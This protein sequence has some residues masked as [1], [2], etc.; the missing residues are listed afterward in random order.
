[1]GRARDAF[2]KLVMDLA[3]WSGEEP[4]PCPICEVEVDSVYAGH[5]DDCSLSAVAQI[6]AEPPPVRPTQKGR[7]RLPD[8]RRGITQKAK[9]GGQ[10]LFMRTGEY[11]DGSLGEIFIDMSKE[12]SLL[13][14]MMNSFCIAVSLGLQH[15]VP[16]QKY[17][18]LF[19][20]SRFE[21][22]GPVQGHARIKMAS[23]F[24]DLVFRDL[25]IEYL[26]LQEL[27]HVSLEDLVDL[28]AGPDGLSP[29]RE[30]VEVLD[31]APAAADLPEPLVPLSTYESEV[32]ATEHVASVHVAPMNQAG[33]RQMG[34]TG[35]MCTNAVG[36]AVC[37]SMRVRK[38]GTCSLCDDC[39]GTTGCS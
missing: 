18:D 37:G 7:K 17:V 1:M 4:V 28:E 38:N 10:K 26:G 16:L 21:P 25:G 15:G 36:G 23:S 12:G 24:L 2:N 6:M 32:V 11:P 5:A 31:E 33:A 19:V 35:E 14:S 3:P 9:V 29:A 8:R 30:V 34:Y 39:G 22:A 27:A 20:W 13:R